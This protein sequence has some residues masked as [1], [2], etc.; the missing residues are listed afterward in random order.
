MWWTIAFFLYV[1]SLVK[2]Q[3]GCADV[4]FMQLVVTQQLQ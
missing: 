1:T 2:V 4:I 3:G